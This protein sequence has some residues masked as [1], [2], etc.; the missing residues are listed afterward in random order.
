MVFYGWWIVGGSFLIALYVGGAFFYGFTAFFEPIA[1]ELS[2][3]Y[4]EISFA[5]SLR[6]LET[7]ILAPVFGLLVDRFGPRR[8]IFFGAII[9]AGGLILLS[10]SNSL[11]MFYGV[12]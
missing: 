4:A 6:G 12:A 8:L 9:A 10:R 1:D 5:F 2:W 3:S 7:G 11:V